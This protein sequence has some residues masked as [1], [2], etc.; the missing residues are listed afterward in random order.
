M[1]AARFVARAGG[2]WA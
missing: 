2:S 1:A